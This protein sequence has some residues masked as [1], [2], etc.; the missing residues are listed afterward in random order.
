MQAGF[1]RDTFAWTRTGH[2]QVRGGETGGIGSGQGKDC[3]TLRSFV[4]GIAIVGG[5][6]EKL[7]ID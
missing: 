3:K 6:G 1:I 4:L 2:A 7:Q 5:T